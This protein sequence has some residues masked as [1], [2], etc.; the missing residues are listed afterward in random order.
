MVTGQLIEPEIF[1]VQFR[2]FQNVQSIR[3]YSRIIQS[4]QSC[5]HMIQSFEIVQCIKEIVQIMLR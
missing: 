4:V 2:P 1:S 5:V 3:S